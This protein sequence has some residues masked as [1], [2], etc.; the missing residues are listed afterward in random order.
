[1]CSKQE[2]QLNC[3]IQKCKDITEERD[4]LLLEAQIITADGDIL[5]RDRDALKLETISEP[6][7]GPLHY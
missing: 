4:T 7:I 1:V 2:N 5:N 6:S 3:P